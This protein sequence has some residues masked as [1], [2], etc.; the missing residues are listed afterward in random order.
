MNDWLVMLFL[1][2]NNNLLASGRALLDEASRVGS[3]DRVA[4]VAERGP[5]PGGGKAT[6]GQLMPGRHQLAEIDATNRAVNGNFDI[7]TILDFVEHSIEH[8]EARNRA[9]I[10]WDH[11]NG[12]QNVHSFGRVVDAVKAVKERHG[13]HEVPHHGG[14]EPAAGQRLFVSDLRTVLDPD[15]GIAVVGFDA[16]LM[17]MIEVAFQLRDTAQFMIASQHTVPAERGWAYEALLRALTMNPRM[18]AEELV[19]TAI[20]TFAGSYNGLDDAVTLTGIRLSSEV[21]RAVSAIDTFSR[22]LLGAIS[23]DERASTAPTLR[24]EIVY[25]RRYSQSFGNP[26]Y[27]DLRSFCDQIQKRLPAEER[28][29][30]NAEFVKSAIDRLVVRHTR[31]GAASIGDSNGISIYFPQTF[32]DAKVA[33]AYA[34]LDFADP[35]YCSWFTF[36]KVV[37]EGAAVEQHHLETPMMPAAEP[38]PAHG[39]CECCP[40]G[41]AKELA[42]ADVVPMSP[43]PAA[44]AQVGNGQRKT[45]AQ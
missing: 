7:S 3:S 40:C 26:D 14:T 20:D 30:R 44:A 33:T 23:R 9:L 43:R 6:R 28:L 36:L 19:R 34:S 41:S 32:Q 37:V 31:S 38:E 27:I 22:T 11:G 16:C 39:Q 21:D 18:N 5:T 25:A 4:V 1:E 10:L 15:R 24:S 29:I 35:L 2:G 12:W 13:I 45:K 42:D 8:Y 17:S